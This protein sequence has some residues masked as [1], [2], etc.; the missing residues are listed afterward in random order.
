MRTYPEKAID[1]LN[2]LLPGIDVN[3]IWKCTDIFVFLSDVLEMMP[4]ADLTKLDSN[5]KKGRNIEG[6]IGYPV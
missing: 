1:L 5:A 4:I 6:Y 2:M 3:D